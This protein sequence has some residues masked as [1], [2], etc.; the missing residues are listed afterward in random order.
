MQSMLSLG[1]KILESSLHL[2]L[3]RVV[4][5]CPCAKTGMQRTCHVQSRKCQVLG[6]VIQMEHS[7][8][9]C[10]IPM[11]IEGD[12]YLSVHNYG[13][14]FLYQ[15]MVRIHQRHHGAREREM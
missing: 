2:T 10:N 4:Y 5:S 6:L 13:P 15:R 9:P 14:R 11:V 12:E 1:R 7:G 8:E 3:N